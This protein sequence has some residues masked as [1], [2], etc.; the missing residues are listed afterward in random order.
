VVSSII[1]KTYELIISQVSKTK[2]V[3][4]LFYCIKN[5]NFWKIHAWKSTFLRHPRGF[6]SGCIWGLDRNKILTRSELYLYISN[7]S[8]CELS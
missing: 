4:T 7:V 5:K 3:I 6:G 8:V 2:E 1:C